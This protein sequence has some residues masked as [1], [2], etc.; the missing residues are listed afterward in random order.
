MNPEM[1]YGVAM[2]TTGPS[3][4][5]SK[6]A[7]D[8]FGQLQPSLDQLL[9]KNAV[10]N[11]AGTWESADQADSE[12][13]AVLIVRDGSLWISELKLNGTDVLR[14]TQGLSGDGSA[15]EP[16]MPVMMWSTGRHDEFRSVHIF[17][18]GLLS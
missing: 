5:A 17:A 16:G 6:V 1:N 15:N 14:M 3:G 9:T 13:G 12:S 18:S 7:L 8:I 2:L 11:Y 4:I 10:D